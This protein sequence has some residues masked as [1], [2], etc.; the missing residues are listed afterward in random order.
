MIKELEPDMHRVF[1][2]IRIVDELPGWI[3]SS[4]SAAYVHF[5]RTI[6]ISRKENKKRLTFIYS[7]LHE[8]GH[9]IIEMFFRQPKIHSKYDKIC[10]K[11]FGFVNRWRKK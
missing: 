9:H 10:N 8:I 5:S 11:L 4:A 3:I 1:L 7:F 6:W 2:R